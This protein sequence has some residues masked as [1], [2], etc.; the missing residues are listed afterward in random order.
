MRPVIASSES[1]AP[2]RPVMIQMRIARP[3][4]TSTATIAS[5]VRD[6][7]VS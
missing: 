4:T 5:A 3:I 2:R 6:S 7:R 1:M